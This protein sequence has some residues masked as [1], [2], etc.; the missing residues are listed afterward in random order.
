MEVEIR[1]KLAEIFRLCR[2]WVQHCWQ[3]V[4]LPNPNPQ[5]DQNCSPQNLLHIGSMFIRPIPVLLLLLDNFPTFFF[6]LPSPVWISARDWCPDARNFF[7]DAV[8]GCASGPRTRTVSSRGRNTLS[9]NSVIFWFH[10]KR[11]ENNRLFINHQWLST[12]HGVH[13]TR[14]ATGKAFP[15]R[16]LL[17]R[18]QLLVKGCV[19]EGSLDAWLGFPFL[20]IMLG[21]VEI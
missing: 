21:S 20:I 13:I 1:I 16:D 15:G 2:N 14:D 11:K 10:Q 8:D 7:K 6:P 12:S 9:L 19:K 3:K 4:M 18:A 17:C 5:I